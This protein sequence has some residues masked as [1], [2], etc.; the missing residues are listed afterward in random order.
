MTNALVNY[1]MGVK[2]EDNI[3]FDAV[4]DEKCS[5]L[6]SQTSDVI[7]YQI[8]RFKGGTL[9]YS[10]TVIDTPGFGSTEGTR[11]DVDISKRL[12][13]CFCSENGVQ[14]LNAVGLVLKSSE[15]RLSDRLKYIFDSVV[16]L[17]GKDVEKKLVAL[18]THGWK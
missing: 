1:A 3:W 4:Q 5:Q 10:L 13:D 2:W 14:E 7:I 11:Q 16:S 6:E 18:F 17:F 8:C 15:N 9:P 12:L